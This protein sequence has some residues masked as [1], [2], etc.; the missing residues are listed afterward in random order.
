[1]KRMVLIASLAVSSVYAR[2][3]PK[4][5]YGV[6]N[7]FELRNSPFS[8]LK[9]SVAGMVS[10]SSFSYDKEAQEYKAKYF[11]NMNYYRGV[12]TC[13][14]FKF[15][16]QATLPS[17]TGFL[18]AE[19]ILITAGHCMVNYAQKVK[20][21]VTDSCK[22]NS[23][24]FGFEDTTETEEGIKFNKDDVYECES[25]IEASYTMT[26]DFA[27][28]KLSR[29]T[30]D[31][32]IVK[33]STNKLNYDVG[34]DIFVVGHPTGLPLKVA[35]GAKVAKNVGETMF[36]SN[37][38]TFAGNS[39]SPIFNY[40]REVVGILVSGETDYFY[41]RVDECVRPNTC[42]IVGGSCNYIT[43]PLGVASG[44]TG[45]K[46]FLASQAIKNY[47]ER[48]EKKKSEEIEIK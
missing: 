37:L 14:D 36:V 11:G 21:S 44:E 40:Q 32:E 24:V 38:D 48:L 46:I 5:I 10:K 25:V 2:V 8:S 1:M 6:D 9:N 34:S 16:D 33:M 23:W 12:K 30:V 28:V 47:E 42:D 29:K 20:D 27:V 43:S 4:V 35:G 18:V 15:K 31:K 22:N 13:D 41:D 19:D 17:C 7:R 26:A 3:T 45:T 39:G